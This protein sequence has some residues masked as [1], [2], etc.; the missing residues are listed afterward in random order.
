MLLFI[1]AILLTLVVSPALADTLWIDDFNL[2]SADLYEVLELNPGRDGVV[3]E[4]DYSTVG[5]PEAP[6]S[7]AGGATGVKFFVNDPFEDTV[8]VTSGVQIAPLELGDVLAGQD[9]TLTYDLWMNVNGPLP[10]GGG[11]STEA[12]MVGVGF[13]GGIPIEAGVTD[14]TYFTLTGEA[15][16]ATDVRSF[17]DDGYNATN[18]DGSPINV[19][20]VDLQDEYYAEIFPGG[21]D[22][23]ALPIQGGQDNQ[24]GV[25]QPG[26]MAFQWHQ[27]R[28]DVRGSEVSFYVDGLLIARDKDADVD[29]TIMVGHADYF[30]SVTDVPQWSFSV[31]DNLR[32]TTPVVG[33]FN[34]NGQLDGADIDTLTQAVSGPDK[35]NY[36]L[37]GD[38]L[39]D[40]A[41]VT[42]WIKDLLNSWIGDAD[43]DG[44]FNSSDLV[45]VLASGT[46]E[47]DI[48][49]TWTTGDFNADGRTN[50][51]DLV[52]A[53]ADG[54]YELGPRAAVRAVPE[55]TSLILALI[56]VLACCRAR[57]K[58]RT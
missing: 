6:G 27:V 1:S 54:G 26:Q 9:F 20:S 48:D 29:G 30:S 18:A 38:S 3:F 57:R 5:I 56:G 16:V 15:Q 10:I 46:Y 36:D 17:T 52:A 31:I 2:D 53:L 32:V 42:V 24:T 22:V 25:T 23:G 39:T 49:A 58:V 8:A 37:N 12:M 14:G 11:G 13:D 43:L 21:I 44:E 28:V 40:A 35:V 47:N 4:F 51:G 19:A 55:P 45:T 50:S 7:E 33:D 34:G 41:D